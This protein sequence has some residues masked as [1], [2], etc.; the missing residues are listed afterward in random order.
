MPRTVLL[1]EDDARTRERIARIIGAN[2]ELQLLGAAGD[3]AQARA[4]LVA[5]APDVLVLDLGL[6]DGDGAEL[7]PEAL[8]AGA[9]IMILTVFGAG[10][11]LSAAMHA[12]ATGYL[13][14]DAGANEVGRELSALL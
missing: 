12:G 2:A 8:H 9:R 6:P 11:R 14:K 13:L 3:C 10:A 4:L 5:Q 1:V 7:I